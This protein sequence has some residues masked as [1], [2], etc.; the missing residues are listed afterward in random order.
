MPCQ[1]IEEEG[2][3]IYS[4]ISQAR[5][6][7]RSRLSAASRLALRCAPLIVIALFLLTGLAVLDDYGVSVD[8]MFQRYVGEGALNYA[9]GNADGR[10]PTDHNRFYGVAFEIALVLIER[11]VGADDLRAAVL[12]RH[13][14]THAFFLIAGF[15]VAALACRMFGSR[16]L[17]PFAAL[18]FIL[19]PRIYAHSFFNSKDAPFLSAFAI[20]LYLIHRAFGQ[21]RARSFALC[22]VS[23]G[24]LMNIRILGAI[25]FLAV[26]GLLALD[27]ARAVWADGGTLW[28]GLRS[29]RAKRVLANGAAF[30]LTAALTLYAT[31]PMLWNDPLAFIGGFGALADHPNPIVQ[32]FRGELI[33]SADLPPYFTPFWMAITTPPM[34]LALAAAGVAAAV[35][36]GVRRPLAALENSETRFRLLLVA[37]LALPLAAL[38]ILRPNASDGWRQFY[39]L[40][41]PTS[42][43][44]VCG[45]DALV[46]AATSPFAARRFRFLPKRKTA[47]AAAICA[48]AA[49]GLAS[50]ALHMARIHPNQAAY[51]NLFVDRDTPGRLRTQY[52]MDYYGASHLDG[53]RRLLEMYPDSPIRAR[54]QVTWAHYG[55]SILPKESRER[56]IVEDDA[57]DFYI[58]DHREHALSGNLESDLFAPAIY[59]RRVYG[60]VIM[61]VLAVN[62]DMVDAETAAP[63][64][65]LWDDAKSGALGE[66]IIRADYDVYLD[67]GALIYLRAPCAPQ[68]AR[69]L[70][71]LTAAPVNPDDAPRA[72]ARL[73]GVDSLTFHFSHYGVR[74]GERCLIRRPLPDYPIRALTAGQYV[75]GE[76]AFWE[77]LATLPMDAAALSAYRA[78]Y[79]AARGGDAGEPIARSSFDVYLDGDALAY[80]KED[81]DEEDTRGR[82]LLSVF[83]ENAD[84]VPSDMRLRGFAHE[85]LNFDFA[86]RGARF[87]GVCHARRGLPDYPI[88]AIETG[89]WIP[90]GE[91]LWRAR[92]EIGD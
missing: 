88:R 60:N 6:A 47:I 46:R 3:F 51:F 35:W 84:D 11:A 50:T 42:L 29:A 83:P 71:S 49:L 23:V 65:R 12:T 75:S 18:V 32:L 36:A 33:P 68:D 1:P 24:L 17:A 89:Q 39:F 2:S 54:S 91:T 8:E 21:D 7:P 53:W 41:A 85:S 30:S 52:D 16:W 10:L 43:L 77:S 19:H 5:R 4:M 73:G 92:A 55:R 57:P 13:L 22:G 62:L 59:E 56:I 45:L 20:S 64:R 44:A 66:P 9:L 34:T 37:C 86:M 80:L 67:G 61:S 26:V 48:I 82:F 81:C 70:F 79:S 28:D 31:W 38:A 25:L 72:D 40:Y 76:S 78:A 63:Y 14:A 15:A 69:G 58:T 27:F 90:G 74:F 87:D